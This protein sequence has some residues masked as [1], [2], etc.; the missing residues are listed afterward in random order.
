MKD[1]GYAMLFFTVLLFSFSSCNKGDDSIG[2]AVYTGIFRVKY[3]DGKTFS[4]PV[5]LRL[6][7][8]KKYHCSGNNNYIPA[9]G[10]GTYEVTNS[11]I[12]FNDENF[13]T[14]DFDWHL[15][16][17]GEYHYEAFGY[18][19]ILHAERNNFGTYNYQLTKK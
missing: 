9:G 15:I 16:L 19:L 5:E 1:I 6:G 11:T 14:A 7:G 12:V 2:E 10:S 4:N 18:N 3:K 8:N 13:W 17:S